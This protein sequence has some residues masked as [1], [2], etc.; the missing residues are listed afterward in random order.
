MNKEKISVVTFDEIDREQFCSMQA[1]AFRELLQENKI[2]ENLFS[3]EH[4]S[5]KYNTPYGKA[6]IATIQ[7]DGKIVASVSMFPVRI[8]RGNE[9]MTAW[10]AGDV[11]VLPGYRG[12][13]FFNQCMNAL[14]ENNRW[15]DFLYGFP[16]HNNRSGAKRAGFSHI[17]NLE[18]FVM[19]LFRGIGYTK[20]NSISRFFEN[21]DR[22]A[23]RLSSQHG[24]MILRSSDYM[25]WRYLQKPGSEYLCYSYGEGEEVFGNAVVRI[26]KRG[27][28]KVL[29]IM[30]YH[31]VNEK[32]VKYLNRFIGQ[33]A[34]KNRCLI[35]TILMTKDQ[36]KG[37]KTGFVQLPAWLQPKKMV[38]WG[39]P[40]KKEDEQ[41]LT[42][43]WFIQTGDWDAF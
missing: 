28:I 32:A 7:E 26:V 33:S 43:D 5:W 31:Y 24:A 2:A 34:I 12:K 23:D 13:F 22:Y 39:N 16:N 27:G 20:A 19:P 6:Q 21:Q 1:V 37:M 35:V 9:V 40:L 10:N 38:F 25:N 18:F 17:K 11:A 41:L 42:D 14:K 3:V 8:V 36:F 30:E 4:F 29:L 15:K